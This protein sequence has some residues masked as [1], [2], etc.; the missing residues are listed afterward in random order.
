MIHKLAAI[1][2]VFGMSFIFAG[3]AVADEPAVRERAFRMGFTAFPHD[4]TIEGVTA[5]KKFV[6]ENA[7]IIAVHFEGVPWLEAH[8]GKLFH[9]KFMEEWARQH[10]AKPPGG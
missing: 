3:R 10:E 1:V 8:T 4:M 2:L 6:R 9:P 7:D 5:A